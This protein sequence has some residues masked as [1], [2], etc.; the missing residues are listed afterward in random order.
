MWK[1]LKTFIN[2]F[3]VLTQVY[4][5]GTLCSL[6]EHPL[7]W[8]WHSTMELCQGSSED[9]RWTHR[10]F[11]YLIASNVVK[12]NNISLMNIATIF[13]IYQVIGLTTYQ[14]PLLQAGGT[15]HCFAQCRSYC[16]KNKNSKKKLSKNEK[17]KKIDA[18]G[19]QG[20]WPPGQSQ[21]KLTGRQ[22]AWIPAPL[23]SPILTRYRLGT[24][25]IEISHL[26]KV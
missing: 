5:A 15:G 25:W 22:F 1:T 11:S 7:L 3:S 24:F 14:L 13:T 16:Q 23:R 20:W 12:S 10:G 17:R 9:G 19:R 18:S 8:L 6:S 2:V 26:N 21:F 4:F